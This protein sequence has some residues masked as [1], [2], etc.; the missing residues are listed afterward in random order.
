MTVSDLTSHCQ[1]S[2]RDKRHLV[3]CVLVV[4]PPLLLLVAVVTYESATTSSDIAQSCAIGYF[5]CG[6]LTTTCVAQEFHCDGVEHCPN[7]ADESY[8]YCREKIYIFNQT[9]V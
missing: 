5:A 6:N 7:G 9:H 2:V 1:R 8:E 3:C 4:A